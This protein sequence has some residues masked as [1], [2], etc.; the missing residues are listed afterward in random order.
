MLLITIVE[1]PLTSHR[2]HVKTLLHLDDASL[3]SMAIIDV[4]FGEINASCCSI[5][6]SIVFNN[7]N[8]RMTWRLEISLSLWL[9]NELDI[10][11]RLTKAL[12]QAYEISTYMLLV[13][14][15]IFSTLMS[16]QFLP[17]PIPLHQG[18]LCW[19]LSCRLDPA[20]DWLFIEVLIYIAS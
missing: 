2:R 19:D 11:L 7:S 18:K 8:L 13:L 1:T 14:Q 5:L 6:W 4:I 17:S 20:S 16:P 3:G 9:V 15:S 12:H 10:Y